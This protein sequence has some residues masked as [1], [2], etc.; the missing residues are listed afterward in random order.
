MVRSSL[1]R[2]SPTWQSTFRWTNWLRGRC[3][4]STSRS[5]PKKSTRA[6]KNQRRSTSIMNPIVQPNQRTK[7]NV[8]AYVILSLPQ[9]P[10]QPKSQQNL[11]KHQ[12]KI[13]LQEIEEQRVSRLRL[14]LQERRGEPFPDQW[15][16]CRGGIVHYATEEGDQWFW[17]AKE[18][19]RSWL[20]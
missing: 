18:E 19:G 2:R 4:T 16:E 7:S 1:T 8:F 17:E 3:K 14:R 5:S 9:Y 10:Y 12:L 13:R 11:K 20:L 6:L 15:A